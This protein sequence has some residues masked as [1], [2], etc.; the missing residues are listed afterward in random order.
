MRQAWTEDWQY[1]CNLRNT[2]SPTAN[3]RSVRPLSM[4]VA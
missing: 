1:G 2:W 3:V 4:K